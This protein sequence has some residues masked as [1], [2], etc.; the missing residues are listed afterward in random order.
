M[1]HYIT[2]RETNYQDIFTFIVYKKILNL[3]EIIYAK[4]VA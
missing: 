3:V 2:Q 1:Q 4:N